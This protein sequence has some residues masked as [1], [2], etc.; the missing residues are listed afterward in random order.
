MYEILIERTAEKDL[1]RLPPQDFYLIVPHIKVLGNNPRP[2]GVVEKLK[3]ECTSLLV[4][5]LSNI[6]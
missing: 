3:K 5:S 6:N 4:R 1:K 2:K